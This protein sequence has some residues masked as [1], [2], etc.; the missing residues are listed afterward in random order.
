[1]F[2]NKIKSYLNLISAILINLLDGNLFSFSNLIPY[3]QSYLYYKH[4][5]NEKISAMQLYFVAPIGIFIHRLFP[6]FMGILDK[7]LGIRIL[8]IFTTISL[9]ISHIIIYFSIK[10]YLIIIAYIIYGFALSCTYY[11]T[12]KNCWKYFPEKKELMTGIIFS[13][14]G[15]GSFVFTSIADQIINPDNLEK[16]GKYYSKDISFRFLTFTKFEIFS[17]VILGGIS[18]I[19]CFP[20]E[21]ENNNNEEIIVGKEKFIPLKKMILSIEFIKCLTIA[22]CTQIFGYLLT[23][24]YRN[25][26]I[27]KK[28]DENGMH[29]LSKVFT[30]LNT[31][32]RLI[33]GIIANKFK[34]RI[35]Y[36]IIIINQIICG[37]LIYFSANKLFTFFIVV[38]FGVLSYSGH[39]ILYPNLIHSKFG[40]E[41]SVILLGI[42]GIF[43]GIA[44]LIGPLL[45]Y[46]IND[47]DDYL[48]TYLVGVAPSII[49]LFL[50]IFIKTDRISYI[51][52][53]IEDKIDEKENNKLL[54]RYS[55]I[56][57]K[58]N[59]I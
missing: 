5:K 7:K 47:L 3:Y 18:C 46:F 23:N 41:N 26:G 57:E 11:Q 20:Y 59:N 31:F 14:F 35:P 32:S 38:C 45:T 30:L 55:L 15:L 50:S 56:S 19:L 42:S 28:L 44:A 43:S 10:Y 21:D 29:I 27:E 37:C 1:M 39:I 40:V 13:S 8:T 24:T 34:F 54:D 17:I 12:V 49:S 51:N 58:N 16:E 9:Y 33:W 2:I 48:I 6:S 52:E 53:K 4:D 25:F 36:L 22:G